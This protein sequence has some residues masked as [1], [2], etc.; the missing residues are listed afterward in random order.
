MLHLNRHDLMLGFPER[1]LTLALQDS[2]SMTSRDLEDGTQRGNLTALLPDSVRLR[3]RCP[4]DYASPY[5][6][7][8]IILVLA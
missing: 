3:S 8:I 4:P 1:K 5:G 6:V 7:L 2:E